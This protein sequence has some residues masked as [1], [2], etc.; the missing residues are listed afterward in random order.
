MNNGLLNLKRKI[1]WKQLNHYNAHAKDVT[2]HGQKDKVMILFNALVAK[3]HY[4]KTKERTNQVQEGHQ[5]KSE[6]KVKW[7]DSKWILPIL[8][9]IVF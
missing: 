8:S 3:A 4:G 9:F 6:T 2:T 5:K 1:K 7:F